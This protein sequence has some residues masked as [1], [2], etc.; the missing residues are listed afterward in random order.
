MRFSKI[1]LLAGV[2]VAVPPTAVVIAQPAPAAANAEDTR[3]H[4]LPRR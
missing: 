3:L 4:R 2:I 1:L